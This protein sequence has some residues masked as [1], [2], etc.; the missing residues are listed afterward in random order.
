MRS[1]ERI[2]SSDGVKVFKALD[3]ETLLAEIREWLDRQKPEH[4]EMIAAGLFGSYARGDYA[5]GSDID[6]LIIVSA[7]KEPRWF[8]RSS[9]FQTETLPLGA[10][11]FVYTQA[12]RDQMEKTHPWF[13]HVL[14]ETIWF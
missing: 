10:D 6:L 5:P 9:S 1:V 3:R 12:E 13:Q 8:M 2:K 4:P 11:V 14:S 7:S